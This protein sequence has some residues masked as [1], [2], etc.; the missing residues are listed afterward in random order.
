MKMKVLYNI[1]LPVLQRDY[2]G[3]CP[4]FTILFQ[5][6]LGLYI[7]PTAEICKVSATNKNYLS[8]MEKLLE[9][10]NQNKF[11]NNKSIAGV[12]L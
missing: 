12:L 2:L 9:A 3:L 4:E 5:Y 11:K 1:I 10:T 8:V 6:F 7:P